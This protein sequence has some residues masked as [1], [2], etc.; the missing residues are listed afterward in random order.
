MIPAAVLGRY[1]RSL[2]DVVLE[3]HDEESVSRD[4][5]VYQEVFQAVPELLEAF[6]SPAVPRDA[7]EKVLSALLD[8]Y[9]VRKVTENFLRVLLQ[10]NR[11][12]YFNQIYGSY[13]RT[14]NERKGIETARVTAAAP[15]SERE[16]ASLRESLSRLTGKII[17][18]EVQLD[19]DLLGGVVVQVGST[20]YDGS[21]RKQLAE[22]RR[23]L[24]EG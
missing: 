4:L 17:K 14:V 20:V 15:L 5:A 19:S 8:R 2:A 1:A 12:L 11:I 6:H 13:I 23:R 18:L 10:H 24:A 3:L 21:I 7:K 22:M 16:L 9:P